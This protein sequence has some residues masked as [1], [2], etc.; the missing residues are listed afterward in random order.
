MITL[1]KKNRDFVLSASLHQ[2]NGIVYHRLLACFGCLTGLMVV[3]VQDVKKKDGCL[4]EFDL[5]Q[6][7]SLPPLSWNCLTF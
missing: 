2:A 6:I 4:S 5:V 3:T 7:H 1:G